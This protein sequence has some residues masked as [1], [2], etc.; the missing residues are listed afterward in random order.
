[1]EHLIIRYILEI[2]QRHISK[3]LLSHISKVYLKGLFRIPDIY[4][5]LDWF[6]YLFYS[7]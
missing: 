7:N 6:F 3:V 5:Y 1:M 4:T 2:S